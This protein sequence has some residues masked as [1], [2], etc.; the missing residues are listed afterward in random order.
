MP[1][2][3]GAPRAQIGHLPDAQNSQ[4]ILIK[5]QNKPIILRFIV[6]KTENKNVSRGGARAMPAPGA[7]SRRHATARAPSKLFER[8]N[9]TAVKG[10]QTF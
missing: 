10:I 5:N 4:F 9:S 7:I 6:S 2:R 8:R 3:S 1:V